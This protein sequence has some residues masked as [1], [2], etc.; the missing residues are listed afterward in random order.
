MYKNN[1]LI[2]LFVLII[3]CIINSNKSNLNT[4]KNKEFF[5]DKQVTFKESN[6]GYGRIVS[7]DDSGNLNSFEFPR[8][9]IVM[10]SGNI[11][12]IPDGWALCNGTQG[13]PDLRGRFI[14][15]ANPFNN[16]NSTFMINEMGSTGGEEKVKLEI[17]HLPKHNHPDNINELG[18][19]G[20]GAWYESGGY[21]L[22]TNSNKG[23]TGEDQPHNNMP[24]YY[25]LAYIMKI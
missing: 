7:I 1:L 15:G 11:S 9:L 23:F 6:P 5:K 16:I 10:W 19:G 18:Q 20:D 4:C 22:R 25:V 12:K 17:K 2:L 14:I 21:R 13:T 3:F 24:P 8:G